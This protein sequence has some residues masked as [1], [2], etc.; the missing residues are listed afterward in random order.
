MKKRIKNN[1]CPS[2]G[3]HKKKWKRSTR[4]NCCC[5][6]CTQI[7]WANYYSLT[8]QEIRKKAI[9]RDNFTCVRCGFKGDFST[10]VGDHIKPIALGGDEFD[11]KNVQT[12]CIKC[13]K[14]KTSKDLKEIAR[15]RR[16]EKLQKKNGVLYVD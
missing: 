16:I 5:K 1:K 15:R 9:I 4:W 14:T 12:L 6:R 3:L 11:L 8:W 10:L 7:Y 13:N 2:C